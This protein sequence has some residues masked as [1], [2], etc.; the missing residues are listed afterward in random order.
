MGLTVILYD[1]D[2]TEFEDNGL[3]V[4]SPSQCSVAEIAGGKYELHIEHP[5]DEYGKFTM[6]V[7]DY[8]IKAP[9]PPV[10]LPEITLPAL[11]L[12]KTN[13][14]TDLYSKLPVGRYPTQEETCIENIR[15]NASSYAWVMT[16][17]YNVGD[18]VVRNG[19]IY[20]AKSFTLHKPPGEDSS[21]W[22]RVGLVNDP[23]PYPTYDPG[24]VEESLAANEKITKI[25]D[26]N[27]EWIRA[28]S[29]RGKVGYVKRADCDET[30]ETEGQTIPAQTI[31]EQVFRIYSVSADDEAR[32]VSVDARHISYDFQ[33]NALY[34]CVLTE[35]TPA[36]AIAIIQGALMIPD[37]RAIGCNITD[38]TVT[39]DWSFKNPISALLDPGEGL[40][41]AIDGNLYRNNRDFYLLD[42]T[43]TGITLKYGLNLRGV[44]WTRNN[45]NVIT[46]IVPRCNNGSDG[47]IYLEDMY[48][49]S[50]YASLFSYPRIYVMDCKYAVG[51]KH[52]KPDGTTI[53]WDENS[54]RTQM[55]ADAEAM[56]TNEHVDGVDV[57]LDVN[58][59]LIGDTEEYK[60]YRGLQTVR[61]YDTIKVQLEQMGNIIEINAM[62]TEYQWDCLRKRFYSVRLGTVKNFNRR[63]SGY[64]VV[65]QSI[66]YDKLSPDLIN[67][68]RSAN[69]SAS[70]S[71]GSGGG[72]SP[73]GDGYALPANTKDDDGIVTKGN[74]QANKVWKTDA[75]GNPDWRDDST[76]SVSDNDPTL[77][78]GTRSKVGDVAGTDLHVTMP[79]NPDTWRPVVDNLTSTDTDKSL[80]AKQGK[81]LH[82]AQVPLTSHIGEAKLS[83]ST[84]VEF[85][86][87][88]G[89]GIV[90][91]IAM[92][93][94]RGGDILSAKITNNA[95]SV[96]S[97]VTGTD[98]SGT[99]PGLSYN[100]STHKLTITQAAP[101]LTTILYIQTL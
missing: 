26:Y 100:S 5:Y 36:D 74:G 53:T 71:S 19:V 55:E 52:E 57:T 15:N 12:W 20:K 13:K 56:F 82:D 54:C 21:V 68:I 6:L 77:A 94:G 45:E 92:W 40:L 69:A 31:T 78:W 83:T 43:R 75:Q 3:C 67:R 61:M 46:R 66:T 24:T 97:L 23:S 4:L 81:V 27:S 95:L 98:Y 7:E 30:T 1:K 32:M 25:A 99:N 10:S 41:K 91:L 88:T 59:L 85:S 58:F 11:T 28:R 84:P 14:A 35:A 65:N 76:G 39:A 38:K 16:K 96:R 8:L 49:E 44:K 51:E 42:L 73:S 33:G 22:A 9:V 80:S 63:I 2:A 90:M 79:S 29:I 64:R 60:Q 50:P 34:D 101:S 17:F 18:Y 47:Y 37:N 87:P 72:V 70:M 62:V 93:Q 86:C 48:V 89:Y